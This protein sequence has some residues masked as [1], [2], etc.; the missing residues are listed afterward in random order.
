MG[1]FLAHFFQKPRLSTLFD[2]K[3]GF[4]GPIKIQKPQK[5]A[6]DGFFGKKH[7]KN[8][9][10]NTKTPSLAPFWPQKGLKKGFWSKQG[11]NRP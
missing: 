9:V 5:G 8:G 3:E 6:R 2:Q 11:S 1:Q 4:L 10:K 7:R